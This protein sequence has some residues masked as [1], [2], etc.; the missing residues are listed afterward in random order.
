MAASLREV[1][2]LADQ[3][4]EL[5]GVLIR[6]GELVI[7]YADGLVQKCEARCVHRPTPRPAVQDARLQA[8]RGREPTPPGGT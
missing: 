6:S 4:L 1:Q 3:I 5:L 2:E 8:S 7:R